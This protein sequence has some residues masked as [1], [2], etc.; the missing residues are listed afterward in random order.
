MKARYL[1][2][3]ALGAAMAVAAC[4]GDPGT[5]GGGGRGGAGG[6][7]D[8]TSTGSGRGGGNS[9]G[10]G[11]GEGQNDPNAPP[12]GET[13]APE[14]KQFYIANVHTFMASACGTCHTTGPGPAFMNGADAAKSHAALMAAGY[15]IPNS[16]VVQKPAHA[17]STTNFLNPQQIATYEEWVAMEAKGRPP[18]QAPVNVLEKIGTCFDKAKFDA[19]QM[20]EWQTTR[21]TGDNNAN[22]ITPWNE[23]GNNCTGCNQA[24]CRVCHTQDPATGYKNAIGN[25]LYPAENTFEETKLTNPAYITKFFG[26]GPDGKP[27]ASDGL[28]KKALATAK[29]NAY[30]H[31]FYTIDAT[32][33][34]AIKAFTDDAIAKFNAGT[35]GK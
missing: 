1:L 2:A 30:T 23:N 32:Q 22:N 27:V 34:A 7:E 21:R 28:K 12:A 29:D 5:L 4:E 8:G 11:T 6:D 24:V 13:N 33:D 9:K 19:M 16:R 31:P 14:A 26:V 10:G 20:G 18:G 15:A 25:T 3:I 17:A 35:C